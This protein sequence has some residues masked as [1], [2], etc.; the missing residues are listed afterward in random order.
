MQMEIY[1][2]NPKFYTGPTGMLT[3]VLMAM[4]E[5]EDEKIKEERRSIV[6]IEALLQ[7]MLA[8]A[9]G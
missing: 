3:K 9:A 7:K 5:P 2:R 1:A 8:P 4:E 6:E